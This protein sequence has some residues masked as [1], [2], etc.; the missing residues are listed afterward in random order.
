MGCFGNLRPRGYTDNFGFSFVASKI[1]EESLKRTL[2]AEIGQIEM[3]KEGD[4]LSLAFVRIH[5]VVPSEAL[6]P[7]TNKRRSP[8]F[9]GPHYKSI[10]NLYKSIINPD[11]VHHVC[12]ITLFKY[13]TSLI[14]KRCSLYQ[15][16][17]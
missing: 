1:V 7:E 9:C 14:R 6:G 5:A 16:S 13:L 4:L 12:S 11:A 8:S 2:I 3:P 17:H 10:V 15:T